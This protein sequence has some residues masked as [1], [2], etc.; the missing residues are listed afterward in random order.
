V[1]LHPP[2]FVAALCTLARREHNHQQHDHGNPYHGIVQ[3][4]THS[5]VPG[6]H[7]SHT[8]VQSSSCIQAQRRTARTA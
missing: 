1:E 7:V 6:S 3:T 5:N 8:I 4:L 2:G